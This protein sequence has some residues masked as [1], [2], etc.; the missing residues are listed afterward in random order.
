RDGPGREGEVGRIA[1]ST[2]DLGCRL[3][4]AESVLAPL[5][6]RH[7]LSD[8]HVVLEEPVAALA[9][10]RQD[11][12]GLGAGFVEQAVVYQEEGAA[13]DVRADHLGQAAALRERPRV[14]ERGHGR[15]R[16]LQKP[17]RAGKVVLEDGRIPSLPRRNQELER[18]LRVGEPTEIA[19]VTTG[20]AAHPES[21]PRY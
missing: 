15:R 2:R 13:R 1:G 8:E 12:L 10:P 14:V 6:E 3:G 17:T 21:R 19:D 9:Q 11:P 4:R 5:V 20:K 18:A 7:R 16:T